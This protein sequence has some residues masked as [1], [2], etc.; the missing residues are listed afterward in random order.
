[1]QTFFIADAEGEIIMKRETARAL[2]TFDMDVLR[3]ALALIN[4]IQA[5]ASIDQPSTLEL[6]E[7]LSKSLLKAAS[8]PNPTEPASSR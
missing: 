5:R 3:A 4:L 1:V 2:K 7:E 6:A 8:L